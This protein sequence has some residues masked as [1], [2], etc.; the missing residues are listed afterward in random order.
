M[1]ALSSS[2]LMGNKGAGRALMTAVILT[3][4]GSPFYPRGL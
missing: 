2:M 1:G 4:V 3:I